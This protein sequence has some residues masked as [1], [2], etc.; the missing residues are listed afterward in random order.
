MGTRIPRRRMPLLPSPTFTD[1]DYAPMRTPSPSLLQAK[2]ATPPVLFAFAAPNV[3]ELDLIGSDSGSDDGS[4]GSL[5]EV[6]EASIDFGVLA[7]TESIS[8]GLNLL[9]LSDEEL[10]GYIPSGI[11]DA[12]DDENYPMQAVG[13]GLS[14][15]E[16]DGP[17][18]VLTLHEHG[19]RD[20][21]THTLGWCNNE[22]LSNSASSTTTATTTTLS[23]SAF[24]SSSTFYNSLFS[25]DAYTHP[26][27][28]L[29]PQITSRY[30]V[31]GWMAHPKPR[32][33][34]V[35]IGF[36]LEDGAPVVDTTLNV[37]AETAESTS[38]D[39]PEEE[40]T[41]PTLGFES[42]EFWENYLDVLY[43]QY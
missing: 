21:N 9:C 22:S 16:L 3:P 20:N 15:A 38:V 5:R 25:R 34:K 24:S 2:F 37:N 17:E 40:Y 31:E 8:S 11:V 23:S 27:P 6:A 43:G 35:C 7:T 18:L 39:P 36:S 29:L 12:D 32:P 1:S 10:M 42:Q 26:S 4:E 41:L 28:H 33:A 19:F 30:L 13:L 14:L